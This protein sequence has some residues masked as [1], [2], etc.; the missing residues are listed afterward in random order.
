M[1]WS[2]KKL[3]MYA[4][5]MLI[6]GATE[7]GCRAKSCPAYGDDTPQKKS[8]FKLKKKNKAKGGLFTKKQS[9]F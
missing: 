9:R 7:M 3:T 6:L 1:P 5:C 4:L 2:I 8:I